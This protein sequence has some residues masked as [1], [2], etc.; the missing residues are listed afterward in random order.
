MPEATLIAR[1]GATKVSLEELR[2]I[3]TPEGTATYRPIPHI[4]LVETIQNRLNRY[5][6]QVQRQEYAVQ[7]GGTRL[8][9]VMEL[10][11]GM[12]DERGAAL[13]LRTANDRS[14]A[15]EIAVGLRV[16]VCDNLVFSGDMIALRRKHTAKLDL[17][18]SISLAMDRFFD[19]FAALE[20]GVASLKAL[21]MPDDRAKAMIHDAFA[22]EILPVR[23]FRE[24]SET[25]FHPQEDWIDVQ[26]RTAWG[27]CSAFTRAIRQLEPAPAFRATTAV[28]RMFGLGK[29]HPEENPGMP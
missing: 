18:E 5:G 21:P 9:G 24:V 6:I 11:Y 1:S 14:A 17:G 12:D 28:G 27:L 22:A 20:A 23:L 15:L 7:R 8:F 16:F 29:R 19:R 10:A 25:Y 3:P 4:E 13:G 2:A 26:P